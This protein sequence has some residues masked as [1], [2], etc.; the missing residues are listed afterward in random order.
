[1]ELK[2]NEGKGYGKIDTQLKAMTFLS[3]KGKGYD[4][5]TGTAYLV[6]LFYANRPVNPMALM[7]EI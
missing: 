2:S 1:M 7:A 4:P 3:A 6:K 5:K